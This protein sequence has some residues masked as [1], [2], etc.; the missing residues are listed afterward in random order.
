M[1]A[2]VGTGDNKK[3]HGMRVEVHHTTTEERIH[4]V[5]SMKNMYNDDGNRTV[6]IKGVPLAYERADIVDILPNVDLCYSE[7]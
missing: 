4:K 2:D 6:Y 7:R 5:N 1:M 3:T